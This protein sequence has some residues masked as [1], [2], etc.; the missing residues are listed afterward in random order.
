MA[1]LDLAAVTS[2]ITK[3]FDPEVVS[4]VNRAT[5]LPQILPVKNATSDYVKWVVKFG[6][7]TP[8]T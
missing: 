8:T 2:S 5:I 3:K 6:T 1:N 7:A 4:Q